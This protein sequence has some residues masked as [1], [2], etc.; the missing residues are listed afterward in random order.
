ME[1]AATQM[2]DINQQLLT[3]GRRGH[4][5]QQPMNLNEIISEVVK[6]FDWPPDR[7][8]CN[9]KLDKNLMSVMG[10]SSQIY[11]MLMNLIA[12]ARDAMQDVGQINIKSENFYVDKNAIDYGQ[13]SRGEYVKITVS[14][15]G[16]GIPDDIIQEIFDPFFTSKT[17]SKKRGSGL[18][19]SV[20]DAVVKD[21]KGYLDISTK[22]GEGTSFYLYFPI[23][24]ETAENLESARVV[25]GSETVLVVDD[26]EVQREVSLNL[27][28]KLG[29][30]ASAVES[31]EEAVEFL[32]NEPQDL[33]ILD[34]IMPNSI[35]GTETYRRALKVNPD[36]KAIIVSGYAE[37][38]KVQATL[39]LGAGGFIRKP[40]THG[41]IA[42]AVRRELDREEEI[43]VL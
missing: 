25:G 13:I 4:Y 34:M 19:L 8:T 3:L 32:N 31:G 10:G 40:L 43:A 18:G 22:L 5:N 29:Y 41:T 11:R 14:D 12:N 7:L 9:T 35:D 28:R 2:A 38:D 36:Q 26:D 24:R 1:N 21:H 39:D 16:C 30:N 33:L 27:L 15:T 20:V 37:S 6:H 23:T 42:A 17:T